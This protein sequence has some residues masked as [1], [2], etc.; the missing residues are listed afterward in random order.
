MRFG[1][2]TFARNIVVH[3]RRSAI[4][5]FVWALSGSAVWAQTTPIPVEA[6]G[7]LAA[8]YD[9]ALSPDGRR[10]ALAESNQQ[11]LTWVSVVDLEH[12]QQR[13]TYGPP[14]QTQLRGV[15][16]IDDNYVGFLVD[17]TYAINQL[18]TPTGL[19]YRGTGRVDI[20]R[21]GVINLSSS[22][23]HMLYVNPENQWADY[24]ADL[25]A[26]IQGDPGAVRM[27]GGNTNW[28][29][30][31]ASIYRVTLQTEHANRIVPDG[32]NL[33]TIYYEID[34][35]G[36]PLARLDSNR[37]TNHW[38]VFLYDGPQP[39]LLSEGV[40]EIG[41]PPSVEGLLTDGR[42]VV[43]ARSDE[44]NGFYVLYAFDRANGDKEVIFERD[45]LDVDGALRDPWTRRVVGATWTEAETQEQYFE[46]D[47]QA[48]YQTAVAALGPATRLQTWSR[49]RSTFVVYAEQGLDGGAYYLFSPAANTMR[50]LGMRY[51]ELAGHLSGERQAIRYR[52][53]D[54]V[55]IPAI[56]TLPAG[57]RRNLP[58]VVLPHGG[59]HGVRDSMD[60]DWWASF[61][62]SRGYA[63]L[64]PNYR[65]SGGYG[66]AWQRAGYR[67]WGGLMQ[68][69]LDDGVDALVRAGIADVHRV[70]I[71]GASYGGYAALA[72]ATMTPDRYRCAVSVAGVSDLAQMLVDTEQDTGGDDSMS[73]DWWRLSIGD[74]REDRESIRA[75][76]PANLA[77]HVQARILLIHGT[78]DT[79]V[80][81]DQSRRMLNALHAAGKDVRFVELHGDDHWLSD[82]PTRIQML[83][84]IE[85][86]L[87]QNLGAE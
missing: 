78:D 70:C 20:F 74:R 21:W 5:A 67:Q 77:D 65:G 75:A 57:E 86:F 81:I 60:F 45:G 73:S 40:N 61:L 15:Q 29:R 11:G 76:S 25:V 2:Y 56:L 39:R 37:R 24:G 8:M 58:L 38:G 23:P 28:D 19:M 9:V 7:R 1:P 72:G 41:A 34:D 22:Q 53:S 64:Q 66:A 27:I 12:P 13:S 43:L 18:P 31:N 83:R 36:Q 79:V 16:W 17:R 51:P 3:R 62:V 68:H 87:Q 35:Q 84:E 49:D 10:V 44:Q 14:A 59:P 71:V 47:L 48:V 69:D 85:T 26:P 32:T 6:F 50:R 4:A 80:P 52:A 33:D 30:G 54:G 82:A 55:Q 42:L 63:V 46:A